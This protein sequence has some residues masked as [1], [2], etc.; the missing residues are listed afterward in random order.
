MRKLHKYVPLL[1][2][3]KDVCM[4]SI[5]TSAQIVAGSGHLIQFAGDQKTA[6]CARGGGGGVGVS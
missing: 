5:D 6:A 3:K 1:E 2:N 4:Q